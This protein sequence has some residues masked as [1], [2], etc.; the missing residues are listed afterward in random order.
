[1][2]A[3]SDARR[4]SGRESRAAY[5]DALAKFV[6]DTLRWELRLLATRVDS[7]SEPDDALDA[8]ADQQLARQRAANAEVE[9]VLLD[10]EDAP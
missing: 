2:R 10:V 1:M 9:E 5:A 4:A 6:G 7:V 8:W 3:P